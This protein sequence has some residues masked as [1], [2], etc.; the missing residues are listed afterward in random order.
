MLTHWCVNFAD[1]ICNGH[2]QKFVDA[3]KKVLLIV[4]MYQINFLKMPLRRYIIQFIIFI[5]L[6][7]FID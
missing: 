7:R 4:K 6:K 1:K 3:I 5:K 2:A